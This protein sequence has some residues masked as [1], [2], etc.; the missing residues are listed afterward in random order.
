MTPG[1]QQYIQAQIDSA[2][3]D[4]TQWQF[5]CISHWA[6]NYFRAT[7]EASTGVGKSRIGI[8]AIQMMRRNDPERSVI[9]VVPTLQLQSQWQGELRKWKLVKHTQVW[10]INSVALSKQMLQADLLICDEVHRYASPMF[11]KLFQNIKYH[12]ILGLTATMERLD[13]K[14]IELRKYAPVVHRL[15]I[16]TARA[17]GWVSD[18][19][20][21]WL[22][23]DFISTDREAY[24]HLNEVFVKNLSPFG[25][26]WKHMMKCMTDRREREAIAITLENY[27]E[28]NILNCARSAIKAMAKMRE[29][30][31]HNH[32]KTAAAIAII[33][34]LDR[35]TITFGTS[36]AA[37][38]SLSKWL[39]KKAMAYHSQ[40]EPIYVDTFSDKQFKTLSGA[41]RNVDK[42]GGEYKLKH[43]KHIVQHRINRKIAGKK[44]REYILHKIINTSQVNVMCTAR[45]VNEGFDFPGAELGMTLSRTQSEVTYIQQTG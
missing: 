41:M 6:K 39:D 24:D 11:K 9:I 14:D 12:F 22:A 25:M 33:K 36:I 37:A 8:Y 32:V 26:D 21:Y 3:S 19:K 17:K 20:E 13:R 28:F 43:G 15:D 23:L 42:T 34:A 18:F 5:T 30:I 10:V 31:G 44:L 16:N 7:I 35:K 40:M 2:D 38:E 4:R 45:A 29:M 1:Q 27:T